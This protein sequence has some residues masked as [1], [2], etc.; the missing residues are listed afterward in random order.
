[1]TTVG[2]LSGNLAELVGAM[3]GSG[4]THVALAEFSDHR[5]VQFMVAANGVVIGEV[6]SNLNIGDSV[7]LSSD[8]EDAL[9]R[10]GF[11]EPA[12]GP[13]PNW[14]FSADDSSALVRLMVMMNGAIRHVL[15]EMP[16]NEV[17]VRT[18]RLDAPNGVDQSEFRT[19]T[20][21]YFESLLEQLGEHVD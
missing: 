15:R 17:E 8:D 10:L 1:M 18:W 21:V 14:W 6:I 5:Y 9:R 13:N 11:R 2:A 12:P 20:R 7:A 3:I 16:W 19:A 4:E